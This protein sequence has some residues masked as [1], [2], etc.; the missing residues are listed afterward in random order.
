M[1]DFAMTPQK[2]SDKEFTGAII[3][4]VIK[5]ILIIAGGALGGLMAGIIGGFIAYHLERAHGITMAP[6]K[7]VIP[8]LL[9]AGIIA[10]MILPRFFVWYILYPVSWCL[11]FGISADAWRSDSI[12]RLIIEIA[13]NVSYIFGLVLLVLGSFKTDSSFFLG[14]VIAI[15]FFTA[16]LI[17]VSLN[18]SKKMKY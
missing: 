16:F 4:K 14:G 5:K 7:F 10:G 2:S 6:M 18:R 1:G 17:S 9:G 12:P 13:A 11:E 8:S 15:G 3:V